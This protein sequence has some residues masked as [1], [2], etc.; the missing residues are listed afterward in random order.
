VYFRYLLYAFL[1]YLLYRLIF[2]FIIPV[3]KTTRQVKKQFRDMHGRMQDYMNEQ[4]QAPQPP[5]PKQE[6]GKGK[7]GDYIDFEEV[8]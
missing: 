6:A 2:H 4:Q 1:L 7:A 8:K 3:Y 5:T